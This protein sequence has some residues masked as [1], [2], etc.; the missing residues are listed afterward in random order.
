[1]SPKICIFLRVP[2][3]QS[4]TLAST[5]KARG[6][7][8]FQKEVR[9]P[10]CSTCRVDSL[11]LI[12]RPGSSEADRATL[13]KKTNK[14]VTRSYC[15]SGNAPVG[16]SSPPPC[17]GSCSRNKAASIRSSF[18]SGTKRQEAERSNQKSSRDTKTGPRACR[19]GT[20]H[21]WPCTL[22]SASLV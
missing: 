13:L 8:Q 20:A 5:R 7:W 19:I 12:K 9:Y 21:A 4:C 16:S 18:Y 17:D 11:G 14:S 1:L 10:R 3:I 6:Y 2:A 22:N 15:H